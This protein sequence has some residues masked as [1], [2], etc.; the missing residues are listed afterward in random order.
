MSLD[1]HELNGQW[2]NHQLICQWS[3]TLRQV[4]YPPA[5]MMH[6]P[7][8]S[9]SSRKLQ[10]AVQVRFILHTTLQLCTDLHQ[11]GDEYKR[12]SYPVKVRTCLCRNKKGAGSEMHPALF[13]VL[14]LWTCQSANCREGG[15]VAEWLERRTRNSEARSSTPALTA[16][17]ICSR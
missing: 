12:D 17:W 3:L 15:S 9:S 14:L 16:S 6:H 5:L 8:D 1:A 10:Q 13:L 2:V 11:Y 4:S 7:M